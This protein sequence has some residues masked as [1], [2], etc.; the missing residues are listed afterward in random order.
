MKY[1]LRCVKFALRQVKVNEIYKQIVFL[2]EG[3]RALP[4]VSTPKIALQGEKSPNLPFR[5]KPA[6]FEIIRNS[7]RQKKRLP[8]PA[9]RDYF[10][11]LKTNKGRNAPQIQGDKTKC[12]LMK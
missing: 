4:N 1:T 11:E 8:F 6:A 5:T 3:L 10:P 12:L 7:K 2:G 9:A